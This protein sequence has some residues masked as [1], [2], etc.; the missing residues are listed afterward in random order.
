MTILIALSAW[1]AYPALYPY[2]FMFYLNPPW[3]IIVIIAVVIMI[4]GKEQATTKEKDHPLVRANVMPA[5]HMKIA[6][7]I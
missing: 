4:K 2:A 1:S 7:R 5:M 3:S 6:T